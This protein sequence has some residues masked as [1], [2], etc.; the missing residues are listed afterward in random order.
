MNITNH[1][2][3]NKKGSIP[4]DKKNQKGF[5]IIEVVLVLAIAGLIFLIVF[6]A[7]PGLQRSRRDTQR[8]SDFNSVTAALENAAS[9]AGGKYP[10]NTITTITTFIPGFT[11]AKDPTGLTYGVSNTSAA[12]YDANPVDLGGFGKYWMMVYQQDGTC[13]NNVATAPAVAPT[14]P[15]YHY[16]IS[17]VLESGA[18]CRAV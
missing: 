10:T 9:N 4:L 8:K 13:V 6:L 11:P 1:K 15:G 5:T 2:P 16:A 17:M 12:P 3:A 18:I 7:L 14:N